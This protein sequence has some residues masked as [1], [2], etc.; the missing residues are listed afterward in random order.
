MA[1]RGIEWHF[2]PPVTCERLVQS[3]KSKLCIILDGR[4]VSNEILSSALVGAAT[5]M[6]ERPLEY[7]PVEP[8]DPIP[9]TPNHFLLHE[10]NPNDP[11][12]VIDL[13][14]KLSTKGW[15]TPQNLITDF[16]RRWLHEVVSKLNSRSKWTSNFLSWDKAVQTTVSTAKPTP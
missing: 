14:E 6:N 11:L 1:N 3:A 7:V 13:S 9:L 16:W 15:R 5:L 2:S 10:A 4:T 12:D 8:Q